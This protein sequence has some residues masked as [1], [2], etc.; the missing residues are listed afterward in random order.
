MNTRF[1]IN[2]T[3]AALALATGLAGCLGGGWIPTGAVDQYAA[4]LAKW[5]GVPDA[6]IPTV[7]PNIARFA[8]RDLG[9]LV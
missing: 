8:T 5:F 2:R 1:R 7:V 6:D 9:F 4:T 3:V